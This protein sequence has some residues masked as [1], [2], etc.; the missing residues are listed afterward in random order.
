MASKWR[1]SLYSPGPG[2]GRHCPVLD[3]EGPH[4]SKTS[5]GA[6]SEECWSCTPACAT[7]GEEQSTLTCGQEE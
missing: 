4:S 1:W 3:E 7:G 5:V 2:G 6:A